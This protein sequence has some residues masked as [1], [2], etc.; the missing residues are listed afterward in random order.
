MHKKFGALAIPVLFVL[1]LF[2][3]APSSAEAQ[4]VSLKL[5]GVY[6]SIG[7]G[8]VQEGLDGATSFYRQ[9]LELVGWSR[10]GDFKRFDNIWEA[11]GDFVFY[12]TPVI[13]IGLGASY[14]QNWPAKTDMTFSHPPAADIKQ[15]MTPKVTAIPIRASLYVAIPIGTALKLS[16]HGGVSYYFAKMDYTWRLGTASDW[17]QVETK[18][19]GKGLGF[20]GGAGLEFNFSTSAALFVEATGRLAKLSAFTGDSTLSVSGG[21]SASTSGTLYFWKDNYGILG[22]LSQVGISDTL[23]SG[24]GITDAREAEVDLSGFSLRAGFLFRF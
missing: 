4:G 23:P 17:I 3:F 21:G 22:V 16:L 5:F 11:G 7:A 20:H 10:T 14:M 19:D 18:T 24:S 9:V 12:F 6:G 1:A 15:T 2:T 13:G 8:D